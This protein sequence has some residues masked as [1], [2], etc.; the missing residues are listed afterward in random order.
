MAIVALQH[1]CD[2][3]LSIIGYQLK[4]VHF[5]N[6]LQ[7]KLD[8]KG[9]ETRLSLSTP[10]PSSNDEM[11]WYGFRLLMYSGNVWTECCYGE[12]KVAR[13]ETEDESPH[14][15]VT[16]K[17]VEN[18]EIR[19][20]AMHESC[21]QKLESAEFYEFLHRNGADYGP[22]FQRLDEVQYD[23]KGHAVA[24]LHSCEWST[25][26]DVH[27]TPP[28]F[29]H[30]ATLDA[31]LQFPSP[32]LDE[33]SSA[34]LPT[35]VPTY[36]RWLWVSSSMLDSDGPKSLCASA[37]SHL[38]GYRGTKSAIT[39]VLLGETDPCIT[40]EGY[41]TTFVSSA[42]DS[43]CPANSK[44]HLCCSMDW[45]PDIDLMG[46]KEI[47]RYIEGSRPHDEPPIQFYRDLSLAIRC[48]ITDAMEDLKAEPC[49]LK[50]HLKQYVSWTNHQL[51]LATMG[52]FPTDQNDWPIIVGDRTLLESIIHD[53]KHHNAEGRL[54]MTVGENLVQ[55]LRGEMDPLDLLF[56]DD[57][58]NAYYEETFSKS[59]A[60]GPFA[61]FLDTIVHKDPSL[62]FLEI[63]AGTG[64]PTATCLGTLWN[65]SR[66]R[67]EQYDY[68]D[69][70][71]AFFTMAQEKFAMYHNQMSF[72]ILNA[73]LD[74][75]IQ[76]F[77]ESTYD[78]VI[79]ANVNQWYS[80]AD[81][82]WALMA[83]SR[84]F[85]LLNLSKDR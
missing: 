67:C 11:A 6:A 8:S 69:L 37:E 20:N 68:T 85:M 43:T 73:E 4:N 36:L 82:Y 72:R 56:K 71:P 27:Y 65:G 81:N 14:G 66:L 63:G 76:G 1:V 35:K 40:I 49:N 18:H 53:V 62:K 77:Q 10:R 7:I 39:A 16:Q 12:V 45:K 83:S 64:G 22:I 70:S 30:P 75:S 25:H 50:S 3:S 31:L 33:D 38:N 32:A 55:I 34:T 5:L 51:D 46:N 57:L 58:V 52:D 2:K 84:F 17:I 61:T 9:V 23:A 15:S 78:V 21:K 59:H 47:A 19:L 48:F 42:E 28:H 13:M 60:S 24:K 26:S 79:A 44:R 54:Y 80:K 41:E 74:P 29:L